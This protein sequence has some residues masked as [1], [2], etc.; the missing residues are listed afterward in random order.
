MQQDL[1]NHFCI[2]G[3]CS[4]LGDVSLTFADK[5]NPFD[6]LKREEYLRSTVKT[7]APFGLI[8]EESV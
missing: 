5:T 7:M 4:L 6:P 3:H 1:F 8:I 2:S